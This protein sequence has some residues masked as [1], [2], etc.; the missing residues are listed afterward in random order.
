[1]TEASQLNDGRRDIERAIAELAARLPEPLAPVARVVYN[2]RWL[3]ARGSRSAISSISPSNW[4]QSRCKHYLIQSFPQAQIRALAGQS[5]FV[6]RLQAAAEAIDADLR[7]P[8]AQTG[9]PPE[10]PVAYLCAEYGVHCSLPIYAGGLGVLAGDTLK[11]ASD[12]AIPMV[13][14]G[15]LYRE[16]YMHQ[17]IDETG[18][19]QEYWTDVD[20]DRLPVVLVTGPDERPLTV[21]VLVRHRSVKV[22]IWRVDIG[23]IPLY[24]LDT[25]RED[26]HPIDRWITSRLYIGDRHTRLAQYLVLG[27]GGV[28]A[29][30]AMGIEPSLVHL[31]EG[32]GALSILERV[33]VRM[34]AGASVEEALAAVRQETVFTTHTPVTAGNEGYTQEEME[35]VLGDFAD[36]LGIARAT[37]YGLGRVNPTNEQEPIT[38]TALAL[39]TSRVANGVSRRHGAV[40]REMWHPLW[41]E[42]SVEGV[43][44]GHVTNG[45][46]TLTWMAGP[47]QALLDRNLDPDWRSRLCDAGLW[48]RIADIPDGDLW[49]ARNALRARLIDYARERSMYDRLGSRGDRPDYVESAAAA[50]DPTVLTIGFARRVANYKR[51]YLLGRLPEDGLMRLLADGPRPVQ[52][53]LAGKAHPQ[54]KEAKETIRRRF[55]LRRDAQVARRMVFLEDYDLH[56]APRVMAGVDVW[57]NLPRPPLEASGTSGMKI[58]LNGGLNVSVLDGWWAEAYDGQ[59][60]WAIETPTGDPYQQD[61]H[62]ARALLDLLEGEVVPLF[63][64]RDA[65]GIPRRWLQ[66]IK[67]SMAR[68]IPSFNAERMV[69]DYLER[70][71]S[72]RPRT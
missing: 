3:W 70:V 32:H 30:A 17:R 67:I 25:D 63:Y 43:P 60:G 61:E 21:E 52:I 15:L 31:N 38:L 39:R 54:D 65:D 69:R 41:P 57:L 1:M 34:A 71:Y 27:L 14:V 55:E 72:T 19:Q 47:M 35:P 11:A 13:G 16:G 50:L 40:A 26:N 42:R 44:I 64:E 56:M 5:Q 36:R 4:H 29:L 22:Q 51:L 62:D 45:V 10:H 6:A 53:I 23:R 20:F 37:F 9:I 8:W 33:R 28:R 66:R 24:L 49:A 68:L 58:A 2:Y 48:Q 18:W 46:H 12:L 59:N 7:R